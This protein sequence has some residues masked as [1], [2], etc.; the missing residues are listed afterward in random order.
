[1]PSGFTIC[2]TFRGQSY[3]ASVYHSQD[4]N[5][6]YSVYFTDVDLILEFGHKVEYTSE[7]QLRVSKDNEPQA[8]LLLQHAIGQQFGNAA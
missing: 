5:Q 8:V 7:G 1:M 4:N 2:F 6:S 3:V